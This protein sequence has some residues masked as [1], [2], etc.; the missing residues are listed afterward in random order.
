M[1]VNHNTLTRV[2]NHSDSEKGCQCSSNIKGILYI[3]TNTDWS[4]LFDLV[5]RPSAHQMMTA[6]EESCN[7]SKQLVNNKHRFQSQIS[8]K[9]VIVK[10]IRLLKNYTSLR[11]NNSSALYYKYDIVQGTCRP[12]RFWLR[13]IK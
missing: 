11:N 1:Y 5:Q 12:V 2:V 10:I 4:G 13:T 9:E 8:H 3:T 6:G 7:Q